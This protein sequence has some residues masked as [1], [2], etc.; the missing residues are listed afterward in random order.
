MKIWTGEGEDNG[1]DSNVWIKIVGPKGIHTGRQFL[2]FAQKD[3]F[4]A[5][6]IKVFSFDAPDVKEVKKVE[7][8]LMT[9]FVFNGDTFIL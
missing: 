2:E 9:N 6:S 8:R 4:D 5:G 7:V 1:T 3:R